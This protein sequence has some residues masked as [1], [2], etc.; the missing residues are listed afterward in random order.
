MANKETILEHLNR[1]GVSR[2]SFLKF[3]AVTCSMLALP[4]GA[5]RV[6]AQTLGN[7]ARPTVIWLSAQECTGCSESLLRSFDPTLETLILNLVSLDYHN[8]LMAPSG[9]AAEASREQAINRAYGEY[10]LVVDGAVP[11][12]DGGAWSCTGGRTAIDLVSEAVERAALVIAV[13]TCASFGGIPKAEPNPSMAAGVGELMDSG[14]LTPAP[15]VNVSGCP[16]VPEVMTGVIAYYLTYQTLPE[17]DEL[18]RPKV[19]YGKTVHERCPRLR[20]YKAGR[21]ATSFDDRGARR[22]W[23][24]WNLGCRGPTTFNACTSIKW[25]QGTSFPMHTG[26]GCLGCSEPD[27]WDRGGF[28]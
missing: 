7:S 13:G 23:C 27:F 22:G 3:C 5:D 16:P 20:H 1:Q 11:T 14:R 15:L 6:M 19:Y 21:F 25:N 24:L 18:K 28:Y 10:I 26:H 8:T 4:K 12:E 17:L 2:R 9:F